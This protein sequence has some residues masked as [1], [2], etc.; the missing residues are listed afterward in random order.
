LEQP[1]YMELNFRPNVQLVSVVRRFVS[2]F[3]ERV[4]GDA[5]GV[6]RVALATHELLENAV[7]YSVDGATTV[8]IECTIHHNE[9]V[10]VTVR[11]KN[12]AEQRHIDAL[13]EILAGVE[14]APDPFTF[15]QTMIARTARRRDGSGLGLARICAEADMRL[16]CRVDGDLLALEGTTVIREAAR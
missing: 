4:L 2:E 10:P 1:A 13:R 8:S 15:Y 14:E 9:P 7:K 5:E 16:R 12:R 6:A 3:Y 11:L